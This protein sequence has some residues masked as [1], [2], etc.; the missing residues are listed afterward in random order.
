MAEQNHCGTAQAGLPSE[1]AELLTATRS[2]PEADRDHAARCRR[3]FDDGQGLAFYVPSFTYDPHFAKCTRH[4]EVHPYDP[5]GLPSEY[6]LGAP[7]QTLSRFIIAFPAADAPPIE[8]SD[9][10]EEEPFSIGLAHDDEEEP[11]FNQPMVEIQMLQQVGLRHCR[12]GE[13]AE[14][15][16]YLRQA[17]KLFEQTDPRPCPPLAMLYTNLGHCEKGLGLIDEA[18]DTLVKAQAAFAA[19]P[20]DH[21]ES[22]ARLNHVLASL[23]PESDESPRPSDRSE[24]DDRK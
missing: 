21:R 6:V 5:G 13:L 8:A 9:L 19:S 10:P 1:I 20:G 12:R 15:L 11:D 17:T 24:S 7:A 3:A 23:R 18:V 14:G 16:P 4:I 2:C 22:L